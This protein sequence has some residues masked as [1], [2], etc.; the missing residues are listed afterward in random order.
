MA[1]LT[2]KNCVRIVSEPE[3]TLEDIFPI[4]QEWL[5]ENIKF[6]TIEH[7]VRGPEGY[8]DYFIT[9]ALKDRVI[10]VDY[11]NPV[12]KFKNGVGQIIIDYG[13]VILTKLI[14]DSLRD[15]NK[16]LIIEYCT[17]LNDNF[18]DNGEEIVQLLD[19]R[20]AVEKCADGNY[21][22]DEDGDFR[23]DFLGFLLSKFK[24]NL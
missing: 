7:I 6:L 9:Y 13:A 1:Q 11:L 8:S 2:G 20:V 5:I 21:V 14:F 12:V 15:R 22:G 24:S 23:T 10:V 16:E 3:P 17:C 4:T 19:Y 18:A